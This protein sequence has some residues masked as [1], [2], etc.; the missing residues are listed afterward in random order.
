M[1]E[2]NPRLNLA[3]NLGLL[4]NF[5]ILHVVIARKSEQFLNIAMKDPILS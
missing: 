2:Q 5:Y 1:D 4:P 3:Y